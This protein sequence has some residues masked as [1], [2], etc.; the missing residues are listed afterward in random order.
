MNNPAPDRLFELSIDMMCIANFDGYIISANRAWTKTLGYTEAELCA[1][2][3]INLIHPDDI[4]P[5]LKEASALASG[6]DVV[7]F[8]NRYRH[9]NGKY[10]WLEWSS[11]ADLEQGLIYACIRDVTDTRH[12]VDLHREIEFSHGIGSWEVDLEVLRPKWSRLTHEVHGTDADTYQPS[13]DNALDFYPPAARE[14]LDPAMEKLM[15]NGI[16]YDLELPFLTINM[17]KKWVRAVARAVV[18]NGKVVSIYGTFQDI[19]D[20][21]EQRQKLQQSEQRLRHFFNEAPFAIGL[22]DS[23]KQ[24]WIET[25]KLMVDEFISQCQLDNVL[26]Q[27]PKHTWQANQFNKRLELTLNDTLI[28][29]V[30]LI[31]CAN[32]QENE[33]WIVLYD[34]SEQERVAQLKSNF[35]AAVSHELRTPLTGIQ[36][37]VGLIPSMVESGQETSA[38]CDIA[39]TNCNKLQVLIN[40]LLDMEQLLQNNMSMRFVNQPL[41]PIFETAIAQWQSSAEIRHLEIQLHNKVGDDFSASIDR[42]ALLKLLGQLISNAIKF[43]KPHNDVKVMI[44]RH[45]ADQWKF[46]VI[47]DG[48]GIDESFVPYLFEH[49]TQAQSD[50]KRAYDGTGLGLGICRSLT[51][52]LSGTISLT[53]NA[54]PTIFTVILPIH[55]TQ[56][57]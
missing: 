23:K 52:A 6:Q 3:Y 41:V 49:F 14:L 57:G 21:Y 42:E 17:Q 53:S 37:A 26:E 54:S 7:R 29:P 18:R 32:S 34:L 20:W 25:N 9:K 11:T 33:L 40:D 30:Q 47:D 46:E 43:S 5:T 24:A 38:L 8:S 1:E 12:T 28:K 15:A 4:A 55:P 10:R 48:F 2:P 56:A 16:P 45:N 35:L 51:E 44:S 36:G 39:I 50:A 13:L 22:A 27:L 31:T 19:T